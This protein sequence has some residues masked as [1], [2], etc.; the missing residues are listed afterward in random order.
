MKLFRLIA[1]AAL[2]SSCGYQEN[3]KETPPA[4]NATDSEIERLKKQVF[5]LQGTAAMVNSVVMS[6]YATCKTIPTDGGQTNDALIRKI[7]EVS[8]AATV[9]ARIEMKGQLSQFSTSLSAQIDQVQDML[10]GLANAAD[11]TQ[12][13]TDL[14]GTGTS[15]GTATAGSIC[16]RVT[17][18][19]TNIATLQSQM[20]SAQAAITALQNQLAQLSVTVAG[21]MV[22]ITLGNENL[23]AGP[24]YETVLRKSD[25]SRINGYIEATDAPVTLINNPMTAT[26]GSPT[27]T[28]N[29]TAHG[30]SVGNVIRFMNLST[31]RGFSASDVWADYTV[32]TAAANSFTITMNKNATSNGTFGGSGG[33]MV[34]VNGRGLGQI[35]IT[36]N[37]ETSFT[38]T[39]GNKPYNILVTG[40][41]TTF[42]TVPGTIPSG[43]ANN[44][45]GWICY[46]KTNHAATSATI[47]A[48][49][50][51]VVCK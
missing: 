7:C 45:P 48:G 25:R 15:C 1:L 30:F 5:E 32:V 36:A 2:V 38:S 24:L 37:G 33:V 18:L 41:T 3:F 34:R 42:S 28:V 4:E 20:T 29:H 10:S 6:D 23:S 16:V 14:Y 26:N 40:S 35:W 44:Q 13:K 9:E 11:V 39:L 43:F 21:A 50:A 31:G 27:V 17:T 22:D 51:N 12:I 47:K 19:E 46:D 8:Q 49:G